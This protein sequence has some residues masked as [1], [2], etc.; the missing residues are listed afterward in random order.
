M[1][2]KSLEVGPGAEVGHA[3]S[4]LEPELEA[5]VCYLIILRFGE[6]VLVQAERLS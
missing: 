5:L 1:H 2:A 6:Y 4:S 3:D